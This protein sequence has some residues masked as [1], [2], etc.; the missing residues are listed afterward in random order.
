LSPYLARYV[1]SRGWKIRGK[2]KK[3]SCSRRNTDGEKE[4]LFEIVAMLKKS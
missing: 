3:I 4:M 2:I 1:P